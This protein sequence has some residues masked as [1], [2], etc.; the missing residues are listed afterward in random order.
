LQPLVTSLQTVAAA[1]CC[2]PP[3]V[4]AARF[5]FSAPRLS[6]AEGGVCGCS[7]LV[8]VRLG[9]LLLCSGSPPLPAAAPFW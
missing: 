6:A 4:A 3:P 9:L 2:A 8:A 7:V 1:G 5:L